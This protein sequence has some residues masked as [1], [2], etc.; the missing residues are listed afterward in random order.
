MK[1]NVWRVVLFTYD[2]VQDAQNRAQAVNSKHPDLH[3]DVFSPNGQAG[4]Y[5]VTVGGRLSREDAARL[6]RKAVSLGMP[7]DSY[8][9][10]YRQ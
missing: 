1:G 9:Q 4:P 8:I 3:A 10:N 6:R 7:H 5:L 2:R